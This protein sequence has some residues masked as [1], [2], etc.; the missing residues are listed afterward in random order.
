[1]DYVLQMIFDLEILLWDLFDWMILDFLDKKFYV[2]KFYEVQ[3]NVGGEIRMDD[4]VDGD[5]SF[6]FVLGF[7]GIFIIFEMEGVNFDNIFV[8]CW[9][10]F[11]VFL[12]MWDLGGWDESN[13]RGFRGVKL[14]VG[15]MVVVI[16]L[17]CVFK[18]CLDFVEMM[19]D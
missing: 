18:L 14:M 2:S 7:F 3:D 16:G 6:F 15:E 8:K 9:K 12:E 10:D 11:D 4:L 17:D 19:G 5:E 13:I 1:M